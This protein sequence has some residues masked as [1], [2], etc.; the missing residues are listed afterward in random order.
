M[1]GAR[2]WQDLA[3][4]DFAALDRARTVA[5]LPV[6][7]IEQ[8]GPHLPLAVDAAINEGIMRAAMA[9]MPGDCPLLVLP[10]LPIGKSNEHADFPGTLSLGAETAIRML[11]EIGDSVARAGLRKLIL[12]NSHGGQP[13]I[14]DIVAQD[15]RARHAMIALPVN[16]WRLMR[17]GALLPERELREGIHGGAAETSIMLHLRPELVRRSELRRFHAAA[18]DSEGF[19]GIA[20]AGR[21][22]F[23]W[24]A[25]DLNAA[26]AVGDASLA[27]AELGGVLVDQ[28]ATALVA[29]AQELSRLPLD[30]AK[31]RPRT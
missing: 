5:L 9:R 21:F 6:A 23:A 2:Y 1:S 22:A 24:Q 4:T 7:A 26:G 3:T 28:A 27:T 16:S 25:Q 8:H 31:E 19:P 10:M 18:R 20:P 15:L 17:P 29:L 14:I 13:Q 30:V 11:T 12:F